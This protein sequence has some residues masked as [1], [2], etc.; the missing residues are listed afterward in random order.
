MQS[1]EH[2]RPRFA[3]LSHA[4]EPG[5]TTDQAWSGHADTPAGDDVIQLWLF[6]DDGRIARAAFRAHGGVATLCAADWLCEHLTGRSVTA[7]EINAATILDALAL[8]RVAMPSALLAADAL[9]AALAAAPARA[10]A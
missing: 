10:V 1:L 6:V 7:A 2:L 9:S 5:A 4:L 8:P 3:M